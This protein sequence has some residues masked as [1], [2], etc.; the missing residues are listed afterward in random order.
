MSPITQFVTIASSMNKQQPSWNLV[1]L[2]CRAHP[3][4]GIPIGERAPESI[5]CYIEI[6]PTDTIKYELDKFTGLLKVDRP[7]KY[8]NYCPSLYGLI[9]QTY[10]GKRVGEYCG[11]K[12]GRNDV[13]GDGDPLDIC[14]LS[15]KPILRGDIV[16]RALPIGGLRAVD[17]DE[18]DDKILAVLEGDL[19]YEKIRDVKDC[20]NNLIDRLVHYFL[21][22]KDF[23]GQRKT[24][25]RMEIKDIYGPEEAREIIRLAEQDYDELFPEMRTLLGSVIADGQSRL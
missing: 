18:A 15:E 10:A 8:S 23:P 6:V 14:V 13:R 17:G 22:Y 20:P 5:N 19:V 25:K 11:R 3:W 4:H 1:N 12:V 7:Q 2:F 16:L 21:T 9:P 24:D